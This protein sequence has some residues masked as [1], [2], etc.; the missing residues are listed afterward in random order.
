M[1]SVG[2]AV[3]ERVLTNADLEKM[4]DTSDEWITTRTGIR[5]RRI[6][7]PGTGVSDLAVKA[8]RQALE[9][10]GLTPQDIDLI[11]VGTMTPD[12]WMPA[13]AFVVQAKLGATGAAAF[14]VNAACS[15]FIVACAAASSLIAA[16][17]YNTALVIGADINSSVIN[18]RDRSTCVLFGDGSGAVVLRA[19]KPGMDRRILGI[20]LGGDGC[21][22]ELLHIPAGGS[23]RPPTAETVAGREHY[24]VMNGPELF[25]HA[26]R[27]MGEASMQVLEQTGLKKEDIDL[28]VPHQANLRIID[29]TVRRLE[30]PWEKVVVNVDRYGNTSAG[31]IPI[32]LEE[33]WSDGRLRDGSVA[34]LV[35]FGGGL[36]WGA[37]AVRWGY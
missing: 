8:A 2:A 28:L 11:V 3:P 21:G 17:V 6:A 33:A 13:T 7:E 10:A 22:G 35:A 29:A 9:R 15:G 37:V 31:S 20:T 32:A 30:L 1:V 5:E 4:V 36:S 26:V 12:T 34:L 19:G 18:W 16:G 27:V 23:R 14:D 25:R 24:M